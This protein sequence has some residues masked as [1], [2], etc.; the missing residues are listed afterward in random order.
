MAYEPHVW[1]DKEVITAE[2]LNNLEEGA[3]M[4]GKIN[5]VIGILAA[6]GV[7]KGE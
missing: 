2:K 4:I 3:T 1:G 5:E 6:R 7:T